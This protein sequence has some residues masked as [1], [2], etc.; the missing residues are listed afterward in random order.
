L[1]I[2]ACPQKLLKFIYFADVL[3]DELADDVE[4]LVRSEGG[5]K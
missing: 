1:T 2:G 4:L 5:L 3:S